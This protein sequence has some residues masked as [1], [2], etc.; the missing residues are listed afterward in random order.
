MEVDNKI[1]NQHLDLST[2]LA[3]FKF[4]GLVEHDEIEL[5]IEVQTQSGDR[6]PESEED[7]EGAISVTMREMVYEYRSVHPQTADRIFTGHRSAPFRP[8]IVV[9]DKGVTTEFRL[10]T[11]INAVRNAVVSNCGTMF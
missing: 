8:C 9:F 10:C 6:L 3:R 2:S 11:M 4:V 5:L 7:R 1:Q